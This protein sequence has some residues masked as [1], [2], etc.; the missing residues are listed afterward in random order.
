[1]IDERSAISED[2]QADRS[3]QA[4]TIAHTD[5]MNDWEK[6]IRAAAPGLPEPNPEPRTRYQAAR[7]GATA[8]LFWK[9]PLG[10]ME[11]LASDYGLRLVEF[12]SDT[13]ATSSLLSSAEARVR[14]GA[15]G[16]IVGQ[17]KEELEEYFDG[18]RRSFS[19]PLDLEGTPFRKSVWNVL[20]GLPYGETLTYTQLA[21]AAGRPRAIR[22][23]GAA[24][25]ANPISII[26]PCHRVFGSNGS[27]T[28]YAGGLKRKR[29]LLEH[30]RRHLLAS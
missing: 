7:A 12:V 23:A 26:V 21:A 4:T 13:D 16:R 1:M 17:A 9:S 22:A 14:A 29:F 6:R 30:E 2:L 19:V 10:L 20:I 25:G 24:N 18:T 8:G 28:G 3:G 15:G 27:L 11:I 5:V